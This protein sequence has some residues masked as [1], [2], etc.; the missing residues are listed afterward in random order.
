MIFR[1]LK[2]LCCCKANKCTEKV[3]PKKYPKPKKTGSGSD[4]R[5]NPD[6]GPYPTLDKKPDPDPI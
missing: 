6:M 4:L 2:K 3:T 1:V 5:E